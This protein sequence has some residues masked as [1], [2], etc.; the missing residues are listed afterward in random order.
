V[1]FFVLDGRMGVSGAQ[2]GDV[3]AEALRRAAAG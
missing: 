2:S 3:F 1:P